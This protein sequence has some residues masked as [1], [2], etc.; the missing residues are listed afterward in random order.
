MQDLLP[1]FVQ[2]EIGLAIVHM[3]S[4]NT[5]KPPRAAGV[6]TY[7]PHDTLVPLMT[8]SIP[9]EHCSLP[10]SSLC[11]ER[12]WPGIGTHA[13]WQHKKAPR[14]A[15]VLT[16]HQHDTL[17]PLMTRSSPSADYDGVPPYLAKTARADLPVGPIGALADDDL[18]RLDLPRC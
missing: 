8:R 10:A 13:T 7:H 15:E 18:G 11:A 5:K 4:G 9:S 16:Y 12:G 2:S 1:L 3:Q 14:A 6:L 17:V